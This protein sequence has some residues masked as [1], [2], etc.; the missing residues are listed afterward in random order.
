MKK[1]AFISVLVLLFSID[2]TAK[3]RRVGF[4]GSPVSGTDY[5]NFAAAN[6]AA[7]NGDT[8]LI[9]PN[10]TVGGTIT[11][12]LIILGPGSWLDPNSTPKGNANQQAFAGIATISQVTFGGGSDGSVISGFNDGTI[13]VADSNITV[14]RNRDILVYVTSLNPAGTITNLQI[15][16]NYRVNIAQY[17]GNASSCLNMNVSNNLI[18]SFSTP[19]GN[20][21]SGNI[22]NNVWAFDGTQS[23]NNLNGGATTMSYSGGIELGAGA[24]VVQNNIFLSYTNSVAASN[25]NYFVFANGGNSVFNYNLALQSQT[26]INW[27]TGTGNVI[28][29]IANAANIFT[30]FPLIGTTSADAR[31]QLKAGSP[32]LTVGTGNTAIGMFTGNYPYKLSGLP[33]IPSIYLL[34]SPQGNNPPGSTIQINLSTKGNN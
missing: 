7:A 8:I 1:F 22:S 20:T 31:F 23:A 3:I 6:T 21:Y 28:T 16:Q 19:A 24:Y 33:S 11:K 30:A 4:F 9:F 15:L 25:F 32:A 10:N 34:T 13:F 2:S 29:P 12:K 27:G 14:S 17:F 26:P 5:I 18:Y